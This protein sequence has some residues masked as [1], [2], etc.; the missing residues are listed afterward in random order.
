MTKTI[1]DGFIVCP[2]CESNMCY[3]QQV[4]DVETWICMTCGRTSSTL[5]KQGSETEK[6]IT[7]KQPQIYKDLGFVDPDGYVW[8]PAVLT[9]PEKGMVY[10]D[11]FDNPDGTKT[12]EWV[13][14][15]MR[16]LT[17]KE[18]RMKQFKGKEYT[19]DTKKT[20]RFGQHGFVEAAISVG[21]F[22]EK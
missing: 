9:V 22:G 10:V 2:R 6:K 13:A 18:Q 17:P 15:P 16:K 21:L 14:T 8:Y 11:I 7:A 4:G 5:M 3:A 19:A 20:I 12:W 1:K